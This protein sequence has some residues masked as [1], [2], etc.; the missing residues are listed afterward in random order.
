MII[1]FS[2]KNFKSIKNEQTLS[3]LAK[4]DDTLE[5]NVIPSP[6]EEKYNLLK[7]VIIYGA[8]AHGKSNLIEALSSFIEM[9]LK[10]TDLKKN[11]NIPEY[12]PY[13]LDNKY[14]NMPIT[15]DIEFISTF[16]NI[17]YK[18]II[19]FNKNEILYESLS[20]FPHKKE[21]NIFKRERG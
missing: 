15:F 19:E 10:S 7:S 8:N 4:K 9:I 18:Y 12:K 14:K 21:V 6:N 16:D 2:V 1:E 20:N 11:E 3:L 13:K 5:K 17:R